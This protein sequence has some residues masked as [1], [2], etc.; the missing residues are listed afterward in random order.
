VTA[1]GSESHDVSASARARYPH[2]FEP[3]SIGGV[4]IRNRIYMPPHGIPIEAPLP[5]REAYRVPAADFAAYYAERALGGVGLL[6]H[7]T[8]VGPIGRQPINV[9]ASPWWPEAVSSYGKVAEA[10]HAHGAK[11][12]AQIWYAP[13]EPHMWEPLGPEAPPL[14]PSATGD[15][16]VAR[17]A[18]AMSKTEIG[19]YVAMNAHTAHHLREAGYDGIAIHASHGVL[20]EQFISPSFNKRADEYGGTMENRLRILRELLEAVHQATDATIPIG[21]R[22][23]VDELL[24]TGYSADDARDMLGLLVAEDLL[25]FVDLDVSIE[26]EQAHL[27]T[28]SFMESKLHNAER[29]AAVRDAVGSIP[30]LAAPGRVTSIAEAESLLE[31]GVVDMVGSMRGLIAEPSLVRHAL[32]GREDDSRVCIAANHCLEAGAVAGF[33]C[34]I[35]P[36]AGKELRWGSHTHRRTPTTMLVLVVGAGPAGLEAARIARERGH[37]VRVLERRDR[38]GGQLDLWSRLPG[39]EHLGTMIRWYERRFGKLGLEPELGVDV[40]E[41]DVRAAR[42]DVLVIATGARYAPSGESGFTRAEL[43]GWDRPHV[44][45][46]EAVIAGEVTLAGR[47]VIVDDEGLHTAAGIAEIAAPT[48]DDVYLVTR[49]ESPVAHLGVHRPYALARLVGAGVRILPHCWVTGIGSDRVGLTDLTYGTEDSIEAVDVVV[50][51]TMRQPV[52]ILSPAAT[53]IPYV[54][55]VGDAL[56]PRGLREATYEG[57]RFGRLVGET[58]MPRT[59]MDE[60]WDTPMPTLRPAAEM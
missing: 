13:F 1:V 52:E 26:P 27:M 11:L 22:I 32:E 14:G 47:V 18:H 28:T 38:L 4:E 44:H 50:L 35:N 6:F 2:V 49:K 56:S 21:I 23:T 57:Y 34:A 5:G 60:L 15:W 59:V 37:E 36:E 3:I 40:G 41:E 43:S 55:V 30:V 45:T 24:E 42:P 48:A 58:N 31:R 29:V 10:V 7:S 51:A 8:T 33:G 20:V 53:E 9:Q 39:R 46:P 12:M 54:Y 19:K 17:V 25:D 16:L